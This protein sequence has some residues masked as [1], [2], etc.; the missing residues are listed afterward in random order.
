MS[1]PL[2]GLPGVMLLACIAIAIGALAY[3]NA[4]MDRR[5]AQRERL[6]ESAMA[7]QLARPVLRESAGSKRSAG[8]L[9]QL[10]AQIALLNRDW[11]KLLGDI[12]PAEGD[13]RLL[14]VDVNAATA[15]IRVTGRA[16]DSAVANDYAKE[17]Q[18][19]GRGLHEVRLLLLERKSDG[20]HFEVSAQWA[21]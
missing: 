10:R 21:E 1:R 5:L 9:R 16:S 15:A 7:R 11:V 19:R 14:G 8:E 20:V 13:V 4:G 3:W 17:L 18:A 2:P 6:L 12:V